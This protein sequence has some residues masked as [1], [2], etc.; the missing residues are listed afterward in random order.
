MLSKQCDFEYKAVTKTKKNRLICNETFFCLKLIILSINQIKM[1]TKAL[2]LSLF[3]IVIVT[4][5]SKTVD[6]SPE[7]MEQ[8]SGH[9]L[10]SQDEIIGVYYDNE[11][12]FLKWRGADKVEP[13]ALD[14]NTF[15]VADMYT[16][17]HFVQ[18]PETKK[19]Y[20]SIISKEDEN[21]ITYDYLKVEDSFK[22]PSMHLKDKEYDKAFAG[23]LEI[24]KQDSTSVLINEREFNSLGY[25]LLRK[26]EYENAI[27]VF[28]MNVALYP[29]SDNVYDSLA[30]AYLRNG[31]SL[32]A[33]NNYKKALDYN[34]GNSR[35]KQFV[36][37]YNKKQN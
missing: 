13:L 1:K 10:Y 28:K 11:K 34:N 26:N 4:S 21:L 19:R 36:E 25:E 22:T 29:E 30:D 17:L 35:A 15:F 2:L 12:L 9:Y 37:A 32:L 33:F 23:Y 5:C 31:D 14:E 3:L 20:L 18:H 6:Y 24:K 7:Y 16:K 8:T 27:D